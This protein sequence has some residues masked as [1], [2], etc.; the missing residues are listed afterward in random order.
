MG[1]TTNLN[2][3]VT[4]STDN[5]NFIDWRNELC[6]NENSNMTK[7][8]EAV[9]SKMDK[10]NPV[11]TGSF[12][13]NMSSGATLGEY[14][15]VE[16]YDGIASG[17]Y[18]HTEGYYNYATG[19]AAHA[20]NSQNRANGD[21]SHAEGFQTTSEGEGS[22]AEGCSVYANGNWSHAECFYTRANGNFSHAEGNGAKANGEGSH[23][24]G[25]YTIAS[26]EEQHAQGRA[27]I[28]DTEGKYAHIVGNGYWDTTAREYHRSNA[29]TLDWSGNAWFAGTVKMAEPTA[30]DDATT[31]KYVDETALGGLRF[32][33]TA[34]G[35]LHIERR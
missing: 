1:N 28:E 5:P 20:E 30:E 9:S 32:S 21:Y 35:L 6:G 13:M 14:A 34:D 25:L 3:Y 27:N 29:H 8:D 4:E 19:E 15:H 26:G 7:I 11:G 22:H 23:A 16:G 33:L 10:N 17:K 12:A 18:A 24:E 2:L 31:K